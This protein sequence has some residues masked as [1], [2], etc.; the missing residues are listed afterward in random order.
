MVLT[1]A[2]VWQTMFMLWCCWRHVHAGWLCHR[3]V[4]DDVLDMLLK[5][6]GSAAGF[7]VLMFPEGSNGQLL[8]M[9]LTV[10]AVW[11]QRWMSLV[12]M[13]LIERWGCSCSCWMALLMFM[14]LVMDLLVL[15]LHCISK[16]TEL[17]LQDG[18]QPKKQ[19]VVSPQVPGEEQ[20]SARNIFMGSYEGSKLLLHT[21]STESH[22]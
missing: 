14:L 3:R 20:G 18:I 16:G 9:V 1:V 8:S 4:A 12:S 15:L 19:T 21:L 6:I 17:N 10:A 11:Q 13:L 2:A 5:I 7:H 22:S